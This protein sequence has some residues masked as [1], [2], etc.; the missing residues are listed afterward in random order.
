VKR[1]ADNQPRNAGTPLRW[2][3]CP[4]LRPC[5]PLPQLLLCRTEA[6]HFRFDCSILFGYFHLHLIRLKARPTK[7]STTHLASLSSY[8]ACFLIF[9]HLP[10][11]PPRSFYGPLLT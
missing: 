1:F 5:Y 6:C 9:A 7:I 4:C 11:A 3:P 8:F 2:L 10:V